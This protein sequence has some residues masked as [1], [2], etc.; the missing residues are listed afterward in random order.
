MRQRVFPTLVVAMLVAFVSPALLAQT[1]TFMTQPA[2]DPMTAGPVILQSFELDA[3]VKGAPY[4]ADATTEIVQPLTDGNRIV[5][6]TSASIFRDSRGRVRRE[7]T[8]AALGTMILAGEE[9]IVTISDP[10][11]RTSYVLDPRQRVA[12]RHR[13]LQAPAGA[14]RPDEGMPPLRTGRGEGPVFRTFR[15]EG[16]EALG[17]ATASSGGPQGAPTV[18]TESLGSRQIEGVTAEGTRTTITIPA[19]AIG[20]ERPIESMSE[21][22]FSKELRIVVLS[23]SLDPRFGETTYRLTRISREEPASWLFEV[24]A[25]YRVVDDPGPSR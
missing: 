20:N 15:R 8:L 12:M 1:A 23:R 13:A 14:V 5:R 7:Q 18:K 4:S 21:R 16:T 25:D 22:W 9:N 6:Q 24:P 2:T 10:A 11:S 19:G 17:P 3:L